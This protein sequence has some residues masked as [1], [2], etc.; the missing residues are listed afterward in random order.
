M[1]ESDFFDFL[2]VVISIVGLFVNDVGPTFSVFRLL[3]ILRVL[4]LLKKATIINNIFTSFLF[5]IPAFFHLGILVFVV[6]Y[7]FSVIYN[8]VFAFVKIHGTLD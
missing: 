6:I 2:V 4:R 5:S 7:I 8:R 3:K 1:S